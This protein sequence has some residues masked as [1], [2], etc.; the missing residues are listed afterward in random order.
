M[1]SVGTLVALGKTEINDVNSILGSFRA[2][3]QEVIRLDV[4][5]NYSFFVN[6]FDSL[7][8]L[9]SYMKHRF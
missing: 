3:D 7:N 8:H 2:S 9:N 1:L 6:Y 4:S 5:M